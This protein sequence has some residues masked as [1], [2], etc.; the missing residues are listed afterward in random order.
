MPHAIV[1]DR[2]HELVSHEVH[3]ALDRLRRNLKFARHQRAVRIPPRRKQVVN[4]APCAEAEAAWRAI[5]LAAGP[6]LL[7][8]QKFFSF[9]WHRTLYVP[10]SCASQSR[11][12]K[13]PS[14]TP[15]ESLARVPRSTG[16]WSCRCPVHASPATKR[17]SCGNSV[18]FA[19]RS[20]PP[21]PDPGRCE[22]VK[23]P[24][25]RK[26]RFS[27]IIKR[28]RRKTP[29]RESVMATTFAAR[30]A[31]FGGLAD[32][33]SIAPNGRSLALSHAR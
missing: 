28:M 7:R 9:F 29:A 24:P 20:R 33:W 10:S 8:T 4:P 16:K 18:T 32:S 2:Q 31:R 14:P 12:E 11:Y 3:V 5:P 22:L 13:L 25:W 27:L 15:E 19:N 1:I 26:G 6:P 30:C 23:T 17:A 21:G